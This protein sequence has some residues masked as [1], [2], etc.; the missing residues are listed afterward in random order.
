MLLTD[1]AIMRR[2]AVPLGG[3]SVSV[4]QSDV[5]GTVAIDPRSCLVRVAL[6]M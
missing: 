5:L 3:L 4:Y 6:C 2:P 1:S